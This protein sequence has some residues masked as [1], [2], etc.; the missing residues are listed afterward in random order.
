MQAQLG[1]ILRRTNLKGRPMPMP[2][3]DRQMMRQWLKENADRLGVNGTMN[4]VDLLDSVEILERE[5]KRLHKRVRVMHYNKGTK[6]R[7]S[8]RRTIHECST[9]RASESR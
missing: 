8:Q 9:R 2:K 1:L 5:N 6:F 7:P 3:S 4:I